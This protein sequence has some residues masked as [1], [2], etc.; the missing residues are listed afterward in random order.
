MHIATGGRLSAD[1]SGHVVV[2]ALHDLDF[3]FADGDRVGLID[4]IAQGK[5]RC[6][7]R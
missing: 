4:I 7:G 3:S 1:A 6:C 5:A 2:R